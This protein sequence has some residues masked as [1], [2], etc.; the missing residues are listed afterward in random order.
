MRHSKQ[1]RVVMMVILPAGTE[2]R[3]DG[4]SVSYIHGVYRAR[5]DSG[6]CRG[7]DRGSNSYAPCLPTARKAARCTRARVRTTSREQRARATRSC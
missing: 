3:R 6:A 2:G 5:R 7:D 4:K 1:M